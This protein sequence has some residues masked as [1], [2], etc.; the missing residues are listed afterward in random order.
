MIYKYP[1]KNPTLNFETW[2]ISTFERG[3]RLSTNNWN[4]VHQLD[5]TPIAA[6]LYPAN[7]GPLVATPGLTSLLQ[8]I[9]N[10]N[11]EEDT[12]TFKAAEKVIL[13]FTQEVITS[14]IDIQDILTTNQGFGDR[15]LQQIL[16]L[17]QNKYGNISAADQNSLLVTI[18][19]IPAGMSVMM[20]LLFMRTQLHPEFTTL[21]NKMTAIFAATNKDPKYAE[22]N[23]LYLTIFPTTNTQTLDNYEEFIS[24]RLQHFDRDP[25]ANFVSARANGGRSRQQQPA[26][27]A[28]AAAPRAGGRSTE[29][30]TTVVQICRRGT[31]PPNTTRPP[32]FANGRPTK[33]CICHGWQTSHHSY[34]CNIL[35]YDP[36]VMNLPALKLLAAP[37]VFLDSNG[38][39]WI[40]NIRIQRN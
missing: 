28:A 36:T 32:D 5:G 22:V 29:P 40:S 7:P 38:T 30:I 4:L 26:A 18:E 3:A 13:D 20:W 10:K 35:T 21:A 12:A 11:W 23:A 8:T 27:A 15:T 31:T 25:H 9:A 1:A 37:C 24:D 2:R 33:Y 16:T 34:E 14:L 39:S 6:R 17:V 19:T